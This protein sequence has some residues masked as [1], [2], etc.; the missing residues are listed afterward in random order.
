MRI[1]L[2]LAAT[3]LASAALAQ[4]AAPPQQPRR[5][6]TRSSDPAIAAHEDAVRAAFATMAD[7]QGTGPY[8]AIKEVDPSLPDHVVYRPRDFAAL[9]PKKLGVL[10]WGNGGCSPDGASARQ[11]LAEIASYGYVAI[12]PGK[13]LNGLGIN[14]PPQ[15]S[16]LGV[17]TTTAQVIQGL[18]WVLKENGRKDSR[19]YG[20][21]DPKLTAIS[22]TSCGG[23]QAIQGGADLRIHAVVVHNSGIFADGRNPITGMTVDK[24][25]L[26]KLHTPVIYILGGPT[27]VAYPNG[28]DDFRKITHVPAVLVSANVGHGGTLREANGGMNAQV[29]LHW[30][31]WQLRGD[32]ASAK[33]F[34]GKDCTLCTDPKWTIERKGIN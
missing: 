3:L 9:G 5:L 7:T 33:W 18:D 28:T 15:S 27:D 16:N 32:S 4:P 8:K 22:G 2:A 19:Y 12:A 30:L 29:A 1:A 13:I 34:T 6:S 10:V 24:S 31:E 14:P 25:L 20:R 21:I 26:L 11:H 17:D 23:L